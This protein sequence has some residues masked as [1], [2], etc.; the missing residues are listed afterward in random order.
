MQSELPFPVLDRDLELPVNSG[1]MITVAGVRRSG[2]SSMLKIVA[3][4]LIDN[5]VDP[6]RILWINFDDER[7]Y[8]MRAEDLDEV[9]QAYREMFPD[10]HL[11]EV[12]MFFDEIQ[13]MDKW[14]LF[15]LRLYKTYC[16]NIYIT[17]SNAEMVSSQLASA[18]RGWPLE[19]E[20]FPL[21][22][23]EYLRFKGVSVSPFEESG[24]ARLVTMCREYLN[25]SA[26]PEVVLMN[27]ESLKIRK[28]QGYFNTMLF[29]DL[30]EHYKL[31]SAENVRYFLKRLL[32]NISK[33][34]S[35][36]NIYN[37]LKSQGRKV[38]KNRLYDLADMTCQ[39]FM[40][41]KVNKWSRSVVKEAAGQ[42]KYYFIDN[43]MRDAVTTT[44]GEDEGKMLENAVYLHLR[45]Y[46]DPFYNISYFLVGYEC[47]FIV[48]NEDEILMLI[49]VCW[50]ITDAGTLSRELRGLKSASD[51]TGCRE[52]MIITFDEE[53]EIIYEGLKVSVM[54][55]WKWL[56]TN[57]FR[58]FQ[59]LN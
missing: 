55:A 26:F 13:V 53:D 34:T 1:Q 2:K 20:V 14:E 57:P 24:R 11:S 28:I 49:Q 3:N 25:S 59:Q 52:C 41:Y 33:P 21:S 39:I 16:K 4:K 40:F 32:A 12:Y 8:D 36:N 56:H 30:M 31:K 44:T 5:G 35:I 15:V 27:E 43:G 42:P 38:D 23:N 58:L 48:Q 37:D 17:G 29:R 10:I 45:R 50:T 9:L 18:L 6:S 47:D 46:K 7:L 54:P 22:F 51:F 19:F